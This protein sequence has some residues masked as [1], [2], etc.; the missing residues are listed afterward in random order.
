MRSEGRGKAVDWGLALL[1]LVLLVAAA[2]DLAAGFESLIAESG[3]LAGI[4]LRMR[5]S[6]TLRWWS[7]SPIYRTDANAVYPPA[8]YVVLW[9]LT[10]GAEFPMARLL[11]AGQSAALLLVA[12]AGVVFASRGSGWLQ[13]GVALL[14]VPSML[15][16]G[17]GVANG[18]MHL[19]TV[20]AGVAAVLLSARP[21]V[22][23]VNDLLVAALMVVALSK[24]TNAVTFFI[25]I[26]FLPRRVRPAA[27]TVGLYLLMTA[28]ALL[29]QDE[30]WFVSLTRWVDRAVAGAE[31]GAMDGGTANA[32]SLLG[33]LGIQ[34]W[35]TVVAVA[36]IAVFGEWASRRHDA[37]PWILLGVA[38]LVARM[39]VYHRSYDDLLV[40]PALVA[41]FRAMRDDRAPAGWRYA[42]GGLLAVGWMVMSAFERII[43][44]GVLPGLQTAVWAALLVF[45]WR[46]A[47][48]SV[49]PAPHEPVTEPT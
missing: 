48:R 47:A 23:L 33:V 2:P 28:I 17:G 34:S 18:Q 20:V 43:G 40:V 39:C 30:S 13:R 11:W 14:L 7:G 38:G 24:P 31:H 32:Q 15:A 12:S 26:C 37:D 9:L 49:E 44:D 27:L 10:A 21:R 8:A 35:S 22:S 16:V 36:C 46:L 45:L 1:G 29:P 6:E 19:V 3:T 42:A 5:V 4:D 25:L 41:L